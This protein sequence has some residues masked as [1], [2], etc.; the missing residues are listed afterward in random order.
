LQKAEAIKPKTNTIKAKLRLD[1]NRLNLK[2]QKQ[3]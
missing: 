2:A 1:D 3:S